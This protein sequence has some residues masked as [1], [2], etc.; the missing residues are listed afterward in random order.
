M[1][2]KTQQMTQ[3]EKQAEKDELK[4]ITL[5]FFSSIYNTH[6]TS[7][8]NIPWADLKPNEHLLEHLHYTVGHRGRAIVIGCGLGDDAKA[9][10]DAGYEV[11][12]F[13][14][15]PEA[16]KLA[17]ERFIDTNISFHVGDIFK[18]ETEWL[19]AFDFVFEAFTI[20]SLP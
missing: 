15:A 12:A 19:E 5:N 2:P 4:A 13:D 20:Q 9:L 7:L 14:I 10:E 1:N 16:I 11:T 17:R 8:G 6:K 3:A 18:L